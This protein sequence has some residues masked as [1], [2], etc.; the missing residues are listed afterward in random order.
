MTDGGRP[1]PELLAPAGSRDCLP[2]AV[3]AGADAVYLGLRH[4]NARGRAENFRRHELPA[5]VQWL[6]RQGLRCYVV[7]NTLVHDDECAKALDLAWHARLAGADALIVQDLGLWRLLTQHLPGMPLHA[8]TQMTVHHPS[9]I[10]V[11]AQLGARRVI[12]ARELTIA[13]IRACAEAAR[14][15]GVEVECF[16]HGALCYAYSGQCLISN[17]AGC[18]S[19][20]RGTCAQNCRFV[21]RHEDGRGAA[22]T[23]LS[24]RDLAALRRVG[25]LAE[26]G[27]ASFK[28]EGRLKG[29]DYVF[30][31]TRAY[32][33]ARDAW[34]AGRTPDWAALEREL[35]AVFAR[36]FTD[37]PLAGDF[38][39]GMRVHRA[40]PASDRA[41]DA[42]LLALDRARGRAW[43]E[44]ERP[45]RPG[46]GYAFSVGMWQDGFL[47]TAV[48][49]RDGPRWRLR[50]RVDARGPR[51]PAATP[52]FINRDQ[53]VWRE[54]AAAAQGLPPLPRQGGVPLSLRVQA[55]IGQPLR[56]EAVAADGRRAAIE[57]E[58]VQAALAR[59]LDAAQAAAAI[60]TLAGTGV[61]LDGL[62][63]DLEAGAFVPLAQLKRARRDLM[64]AL[65]AAPAERP[66]QPQ[67]PDGPPRPRRTR[68]WVVAGSVEALAAARQAGADEVVLDDPGLDAQGPFALPDG[69]WLRI[70]ATAPAAAAPAPLFAGHLGALAAARAAG[71]PA[72]ADAALNVTNRHTLAQLAELG[73]TAA[74]LSLE[75]SGREIARLAGRIADLPIGVLVVVHGR[76]PAMLTRQD[77]GLAIGETRR[78]RAVPEEGGLPYE[79]QRRRHDTVLWEGRRLCAPEAA[80]AT[81]GLV[82]GW[83][84][85]LAD[86]GP[87]AVAELTAAYARLIAGTAS[88]EEV[89]ARAARHAPLG[90][91]PGHLAI[92]ARALDAVAQRAPAFRAR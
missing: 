49:Q 40:D 12:L 14:R 50:V 43:I 18:R 55:R 79:L 80:A 89:R 86:L 20:N 47:V 85:E 78:I 67:L 3:A 92:G 70:P 52:L 76:V 39:E 48:E 45:P 33:Q 32:R 58:P 9:Q 38:G 71:L 74:V 29:P 61:V 51:A 23:L 6:H 91:F 11:L 53:A 2:A 62:T 88:A 21:Y 28:I 35:R 13:E 24:L 25:E 59:P 41:P 36:P 64:A 44:A 5:L 8:S 37:G 66:P 77:H 4:F 26:A 63:L 10:A 19:A 82:D 60:G 56:L 90:L 84:L 16:V 73:A 68:L 75:L 27:V 87:E 69:A 7:L 17:F 34:A 15:C 72:I 57:G 31:V 83:V 54:L 46:L 22:D 42:R 65:A 1:R 81:L 30:A